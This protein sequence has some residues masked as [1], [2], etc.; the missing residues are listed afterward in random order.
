MCR[1]MMSITTICYNI[2][3]ATTLLVK[4]ELNPRLEI[5]LPVIHYGH[6]SY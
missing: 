3:Y 4:P 1:H 6:F 2:H 5:E